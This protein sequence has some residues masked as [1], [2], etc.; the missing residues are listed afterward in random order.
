MGLIE[1][2]AKGFDIPSLVVFFS[3]SDSN[4]DLGRIQ[5]SET[6]GRGD[7]WWYVRQDWKIKS[8]LG[9]YAK[10]CRGSQL[11]SLIQGMISRRPNSCSIIIERVIESEYSGCVLVK[12]GYVMIESVQ[13]SLESLTHDG[14]YLDRW[15]CRLNGEVMDHLSGNQRI[16]YDLTNGR[17]A[18]SPINRAILGDVITGAVTNQPLGAINENGL[19]EWVID[20]SGKV[21]VIDRKALPGT[22]LRHRPRLGE[23]LVLLDQPRAKKTWETRKAEVLHFKLPEYRVTHHYSRNIGGIVFNEGALLAH[24]TTY[25]AALGIPIT[26]LR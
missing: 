18:K 24:A 11:Q 2:S 20:P 23:Q 4:F 22:F 19:I 8:G 3:G 14:T 9:K 6:L 21:F 16:R 10:I 12:R 7:G 5:W 13:G 15:I 26:F 25:A 17:L 1:L